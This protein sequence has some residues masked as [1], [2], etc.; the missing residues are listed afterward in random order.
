MNPR[1]RIA[2]SLGSAVFLFASPAFADVDFYGVKMPSESYAKSLIVQGYNNLYTVSNDIEGVDKDVYAYGTLKDSMGGMVLSLRVFN[3]SDRPI[4]AD[5]DF[6]EYTVV[7]KDGKRYTLEPPVMAW[8]SGSIKPKKSETFEPGLGS[9]KLKKEDIAEVVCSFDMGSTKIVLVPVRKT[10]SKLAVVKTQASKPAAPKVEAPKPIAVKPVATKPFAMS[11]PVAAAA[12][13][14]TQ[15]PPVSKPAFTKPAPKLLPASAPV[16]AK[17]QPTK[18]SPP[19]VA[20]KSV[21]TPIFKP[22][23]KVA[24]PPVPDLPNL[25]VRIAEVHEADGFFI[26]NGGAREGF[27][28]DMI[29]NVYRADRFVG[30]AV[31]RKV[32]DHSSAAMIIPELTDGQLV[33]G[34][35]VRP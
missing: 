6:I 8:Y 25:D 12:P 16:L 35:F 33:V 17:T 26:L 4:L 11:K 22:L 14:L 18:P 19:V 7:T 9:L 23:P 28:A 5:Y 20:T 2:A 3:N 29:V 15:P 21:S 34:D 10:E 27:K 30:K 13:K 31:I 1:L 32:K 24:Q